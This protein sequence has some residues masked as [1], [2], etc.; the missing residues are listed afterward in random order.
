M[1]KLQQYYESLPL[2]TGNT[3]GNVMFSVYN[4]IDNLG[5]LTR[6]FDLPD[7][8]AC[9]EVP[10]LTFQRTGLPD[11]F[12]GYPCIAVL[13][14][15]NRAGDDPFIREHRPTFRQMYL[16]GYAQGEAEG[17]QFLDRMAA[18]GTQSI[19][20][21]RAGLLKI[22][23]KCRAKY[24]NTAIFDAS[25]LLKMG[26]YAGYMFTIAAA[27][28]AMA[29]LI[30]PGKKAGRK[31]ADISEIITGDYAV[32]INRVRDAIN[33]AVGDKAE[34]VADEIRLIQRDGLII[35]GSLDKKVKALYDFLKS[36]IAD[37]PAY[38]HVVNALDLT[39][40]N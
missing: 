6:W 22:F 24:R 4:D 36:N 35:G 5:S 12:A 7:D 19:A 14:F 17:R 40:V 20:D 1:D 2:C 15:G 27:L 23:G 21:R 10:N 29:L 37:M 34:A 32:V 38:Q 16:D 18:Y 8:E 28:V 9:N 13:F 26:H 25:L 31:K 30:K 33:A 3:P 39:A 11:A